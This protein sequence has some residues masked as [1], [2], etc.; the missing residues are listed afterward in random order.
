MVKIKHHLLFLNIFV[1]IG[2][3]LFFITT[4]NS[5]MAMENNTYNTYKGEQKK[6][7]DILDEAI[8]H[9]DE[10]IKYFNKK[11]IQIILDKITKLLSKNETKIKKR[12]ITL[13][14][15]NLFISKKSNKNKK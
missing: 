3:S 5:V 2:L 14:E 1:F 10:A 9:L 8:E 7:N 15:Q 11:R 13:E 6:D 4:N 12:N